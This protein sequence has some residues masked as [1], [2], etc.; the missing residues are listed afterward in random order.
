MCPSDQNKYILFQDVSLQF[1][2]LLAC[3][4]SYY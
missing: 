2:F 1:I 4:F 3:L